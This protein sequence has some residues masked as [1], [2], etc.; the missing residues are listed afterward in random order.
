MLA[1]TQSREVF[2]CPPLRKFLDETLLYVTCVCRTRDVSVDRLT[3]WVSVET[4]KLVSDEIQC[5]SLELNWYSECYN[6]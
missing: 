2:D 4:N 1:P 3:T 6:R 5:F